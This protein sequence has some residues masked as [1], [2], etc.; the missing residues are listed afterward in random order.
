[1]ETKRTEAKYCFLSTAVLETSAPQLSPVIKKKILICGIWE[2]NGSWTLEKG[3]SLLKLVIASQS[4]SVSPRITG[5][6]L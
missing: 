2:E 1:M 5:L 4:N 3:S 6:I